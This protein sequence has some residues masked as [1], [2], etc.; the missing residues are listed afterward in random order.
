MTTEWRVTACTARSHRGEVLDKPSVRAATGSRFVLDLRPTHLAEANREER[1][2]LLELSMAL[3]GALAA[4][5][6]ARAARR[7]ALRRAGAAFAVLSLVEETLP[8]DPRSRYRGLRLIGSDADPLTDDA[9]LDFA[10]STPMGS[11][12]LLREPL[13]LQGVAGEDLDY[14]STSPLTGGRAAA[15][16]SVVLH[17]PLLG[18]VLAPD[19]ASMPSQGSA[20]EHPGPGASSAGHAVL[21]VLTIGWTADTVLPLDDG[22][23]EAFDAVAAHTAQALARA[24]LFE[25]QRSV[26]QSLQKAVLPWRL[27]EPAGWQLAARYVPATR[28][29][30]VGGD[31]YDAFAL[32]GGRLALVVG[33]ATGHGLEAARMM[34]GLRNS[35]RAYAILGDGP[36]ATLARLDTLL[37]VTAPEALATVVY[38]EISPRD[39]HV[40]WASA[41]HPPPLL[42]SALSER[43]ASFIAA[44]DED[45]DPPLGA[46]LP[47]A[48]GR[49]AA[50]SRQERSWQLEPGETLLLYTDGLIERRDHDVAKG[51]AKL[52]AA[53]LITAGARPAVQVDSVIGTLIDAS[54]PADDVCVLALSRSVT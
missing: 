43:A 1:P 45:V 32:P 39:G 50:P 13:L 44:V 10:A 31:W 20:P 19:H 6:V 24:L 18:S 49:G 7:W 22:T 34:S 52:R 25:Q 11:T 33:D 2:A 27:P 14:L 54:G 16:S 21:G 3:S 35:L 5:D 15:A 17:L 42:V 51:L 36:A 46:R 37:D 9:R 40:V 26:A 8:G 48:D 41:G 47:P 4:D 30:V 23:R 28:H 38:L 53:A 29:L 12:V